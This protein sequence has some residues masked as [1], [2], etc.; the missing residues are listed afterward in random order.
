MEFVVV[1]VFMVGE[2]N[3]SRSP[4]IQPAKGVLTVSA[5]HKMLTA[6]SD[7]VQSDESGQRYPTDT[8]SFAAA[9]PYSRL[10][11]DINVALISA[12]QTASHS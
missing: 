4:K 2:N 11:R 8:A 12:G 1:P 10:S 7:F 9:A 3:P 6:H 5:G